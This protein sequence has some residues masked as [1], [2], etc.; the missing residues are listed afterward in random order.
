M[1]TYCSFGFLSSLSLHTGHPTSHCLFALELASGSC[2]RYAI[3]VIHVRYYDPICVR[4]VRW[5]RKLRNY[6]GG[7]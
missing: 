6:C 3:L 4:L 1:F 2:R 5:H 7:R